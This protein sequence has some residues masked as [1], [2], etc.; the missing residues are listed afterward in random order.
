MKSKYP[1]LGL[2]III[3]LII[4]YFMFVEV[5][6]VDLILINGNFPLNCGEEQSLNSIVINN[7]RIIELG[8]SEMMIK[9]YQSKNVVDLQGGYIFP[10]FIDSHAHIYGLGML[11]SSLNLT[12]ITSPQE[13]AQ[14]VKK[15]CS[16]KTAG[17]WIYGRGWDQTLWT[18][19]EFPTKNIL[20]SVS[21]DHPIIL[22]RIDGHAIWVNSKA[23]E[24]AGINKNTPDPSGGKIIRD[25]T[26]EPTGIL[27]DKA[28][29][30][31]E[32]IVPPPTD[33]EIES[34][35]TKALLECTKVGLT[36]IHDM[37]VNS[38]LIRIY[39]K[40][41][42]EKRL[43]LRVY[44]AIDIQDKDWINFLK[45]GPTINY[46][47]GMLNIRSVKLYADG[48]LGSRGAALI[49][50]YSDDVGNRGLTLLSETELE[51]VSRQAIKYNF[52]VCVH[53][54][55]DRANHIVLN[56]FE[57][58]LKDNKKLD[59]RLRIEH[60]QVIAKEDMNRF[61]ALKIIPS[62]QPVHCSSDMDWAEKRLGPE[63][64]KG[65]YAWQSLL[66][67]GAIIPAGSDFPNDL[68]HPLVGFYAA[69]TRKD[70]SGNPTN[71]WYPEECMS[72]EQAL[73]AYTIWGAYAAFQEEHLGTIEIGKYADFT[74]LSKNIMTIPEPEILTTEVICTIVNGNI[75]YSKIE[76]K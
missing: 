15:E 11:L 50:S 64:V 61:N 33:V 2:L 5:D 70:I 14:L 23:L 28:T 18:S 67:T 45:E 20:D 76:V 51:E 17:E 58:I 9:K 62:M 54:I 53:A 4:T 26:G 36:E 72:R 25:K 7:G 65:A 44:C 56:V 34:Y 35:L 41:A 27:I 6:K 12:G 39:K 43:P 32:Q 55:G 21:V 22:G 3:F 71:G 59:L 8:P 48:A 49:E 1:L 73:K 52:Q 30:L 60:A 63:R 16:Q 40:L 46:A 42:D 74:V 31:V 57:K 75:V 66:K 24:L 10:G 38:Q 29:E 68:M 13:I 19:S 37:G 69:I 47:G